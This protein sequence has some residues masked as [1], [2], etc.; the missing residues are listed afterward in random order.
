MHVQV[1]LTGKKALVTGSNSGIG[2]AIAM[3]IAQAGA[4]VAINYV[5]HPEAAQEVVRR[6]EA[7]GRRAIAVE[8]DVSDQAQ[9]ERMFKE[10]DQKLGGVDIVVNNAGI[11]GVRQEG[12]EI[13]PADWR[14]VIDIN[15]VGA[16]YCAREGLRRM[17]EKRSGVVLNMTS[18]HE[19]IPWSG[20]SAY[21]TSKAG[22]GMLTKTLAQEVAPYGVRVLALAPGAIK[23]AINQSVWGD[24]AGLKDL[25]R[26]IPMGRMGSTEE[27]A[28]MAV[29]LVSDIASY[30]T[31]TT[32]LVDGGMTLYE[33]FSHGG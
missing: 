5:T 29:V 17:V 23:T 18:V 13:A 4:D 31:G 27:I 12:H 7:L 8:A 33:D 25:D 9:V 32:V 16:F 30:V 14:K 2:E 20:Y 21:T 3:A 6:I 1:E 24:A 28:H 11:D 26:K 15:L 19:M 10:A 22:L